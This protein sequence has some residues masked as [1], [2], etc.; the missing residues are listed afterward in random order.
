MCCFC[1]WGW[2]EPI[3]KIYLKAVADLGGNYW[4]LHFGPA[5]TVWE[6][7]NFEC[8]QR[9]LDNFEEYSRYN[10]NTAAQLEVVTRSLRELLDVPDELKECPEW[11]DDNEP[12]LR[13]PFP[14][15]KMIKVHELR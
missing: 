11:F 15:V 13:N 3:A 4:P 6:D 10:N 2:P 8:A 9:C 1:Y 7:A 5:H 14:G 12:G